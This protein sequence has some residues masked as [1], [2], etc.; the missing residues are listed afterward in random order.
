MTKKVNFAKGVFIKKNYTEFG[1]EKIDVSIKLEDFE[2]NNVTKGGYINFEIIKA[3]S[4]KYY[5]RDRV[6]VKTDFVTEEFLPHNCGEGRY[7]NKYYE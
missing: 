2:K 5:A 3:K 1:E 6:F 7:S 4:G